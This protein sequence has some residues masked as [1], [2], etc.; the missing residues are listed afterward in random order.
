M[1]AAEL[2][3]NCGIGCAEVEGMWK[4]GLKAEG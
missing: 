2:E 4:Q 1:A 3:S